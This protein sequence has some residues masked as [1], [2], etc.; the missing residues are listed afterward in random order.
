MII[1]ARYNR[2]TINDRLRM[3]STRLRVSGCSLVS[4]DRTLEQTAEAARHA[5]DLWFLNCGRIS[6]YG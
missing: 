1:E 4:R 5:S 3:S 2:H 6:P